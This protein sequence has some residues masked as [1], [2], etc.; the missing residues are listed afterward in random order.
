MLATPSFPWSALVVSRPAVS[1]RL[2]CVLFF[3]SSWLI[4]SASGFLAPEIFPS[5]L[6]FLW[7]WGPRDGCD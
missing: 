1:R 6:D 2:V 5:C 4:I 3:S 7:V